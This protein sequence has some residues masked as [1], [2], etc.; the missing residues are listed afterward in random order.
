ML[1]V[2]SGL[3]SLLRAGVTFWC[4]TAL[5]LAAD[6][7]K[8]A[9]DLP[10]DAAERSLR[11]FATQSGQEVLFTTEVTAGVE[12]NAVQGEHT[13]REAMDRLIAGTGLVSHQAPG[14][15]WRVLRSAREK[16]E[17]AVPPASRRAGAA[18][19]ATNGSILGAVSNAATGAYLE[20]AEVTLD[21]QTLPT[22]T[23][24]DGTFHFGQV[25]AGAHTLRVRYAGLDVSERAV[26]VAPGQSVTIGIALTS[27]VY[28]LQ[29]FNV[30]AE[31]EGNAASITRQRNAGNIINVV[32]IDAYGDIAD[33]N[34]ANFM[35][36]LPG[37]A[38]HSAE[39]DNVGVMLRG[40]PPGMSM[41]SL[42]GTQMT[43][44]ASMN[45]GTLGDRAPTLDRIPAEF[46]KEVEV[47]KA[48]TPDMDA[49]GLGG[50]AKLITKSAFDFKERGLTTYRAAMNRNTYRGQNPWTSNSAFTVM[51][52]LGAEDRLALTFSGSYTKTLVTRDRVQMVRNDAADITT[53]LRFLDD[54]YDRERMGGGL[55][56]EYKLNDT[57][58]LYL[59][60][61]YSLYTSDTTRFDHQGA[62]AGGR[63]FV[64]YNIV[65]RAAIEAGTQPLNSARQA[66]SIAPGYTADYLELLHS[67][68]LNR[69]AYDLR[70]E[71]QYFAALGGRTKL[72]AFEITGRTTL[73]RDRYDRT[74]EQFTI[75][76][77]RIGFVTDQRQS[78]LRPIFRQTYGPSLADYSAGTGQLNKS[79]IKINEVVAATNL[80]VKRAFERGTVQGFLKAGGK[81]QYQNR[82]TAQWSPVWDFTGADGVI[83]RVAATGVNDDNLE[84]FKLNG[85]AYGLFDY[86]Y[87][88]FPSIDYWAA[89][90]LF[91]SQ[92]NLF[93][94]NGTSVSNRA[95][96]SEATEEVVAGY[97]MAQARRGRLT[98]VGGIRAEETTVK[99]KGVLTQGSNIR[100]T[101]RA[102]DYLKYFPSAHLRYELRRNWVLRSSYSTTMARPSITDITP[103]TT[104]TTNA[105][106]GLG[107]VSQNN[108]DL[109]P[110]TSRNYDVMMEYYFNPVGVLTA[111]VFRKNI[112]GFIASYTTPIDD[113]RDNGFD[114][115]FAGYNLVTKRNLSTARLEGYELS[116]DQQL[117]MLPKPFNT[118]SLFANYTRV[119][120]TGTYDNGISDLPSFVPEMYNC[121]LSYSLWR[122]QVRV[123]YNYTGPYLLSYNANPILSTW[124]TDNDTLGLNVQFRIGA[125]LNASFN[126]ENVANHWARN[127]TV[128]PSR[129]TVSEVYGSRV[130]VG[131]NG[132]F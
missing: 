94:P 100:L 50:A 111:G 122:L 44:A 8:R 20:G 48:S 78:R 105:T 33:G 27:G 97:A 37:V 13:P 88:S 117:R 131:V 125:R 23:S 77:P 46:I 124:Q 102:G 49:N 83:G 128:N 126:W 68:W 80:D 38:V 75:T 115:Q 11:R 89:D 71:P 107:T 29:A 65:S 113:G 57:T 15:A 129:V 92:R 121:G 85:T 52:K 79:V 25:A 59:D 32:A 28:Q 35:Q 1:G 103:T 60:T 45:T 69:A 26:E 30:S 12:T 41:V 21:G 109:G 90:R 22:L 106:T 14:G 112:D 58:S 55:K 91:E 86:F 36:K 39:G 119:K 76:T 2:R 66:A 99:A 64:D 87:P 67:N 104:I 98:G 6:P 53:G 16:A 56:V 82:D 127:Y 132:R 73:G 108:T 3:R 84:Q 17:E 19:G 61:L 4:L 110:Q 120:A 118:L 40:A 10:K 51:R 42:D 54:A 95:P 96:P 116:Y 24:R 62:D 5:A 31:R 70:Q 72:G 43:A 74:F 123:S 18:A 114:G 7:G 9:F 93:R 34:V 101:E 81:Y 63:R 130:T 47:T